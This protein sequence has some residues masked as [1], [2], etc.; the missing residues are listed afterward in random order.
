[1]VRGPSSTLSSGIF[2]LP[3]GLL[4]TP[5]NDLLLCFPLIFYFFLRI[6]TNHPTLTR[7]AKEACSNRTDRCQEAPCDCQSRNPGWGWLWAMQQWLSLP[8][9]L[10]ARVLD[11][12]SPCRPLQ[13]GA[14]DT[15]RPTPLEE[16]ARNTLGRVS[17]ELQM[18]RTMEARKE[19]RAPGLLE[20][21]S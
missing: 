6:L 16:L 19:T 20:K 17:E 13:P 1:M 5:I 21:Q 8:L 9:P 3:D 14:Q 2:V 18:P 11:S 4:S 7:H 12:G 15:E 10:A